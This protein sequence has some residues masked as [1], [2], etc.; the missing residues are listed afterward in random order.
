[1]PNRAAEGADDRI[2]FA[3]LCDRLAQRS[4]GQEPP[5]TEAALTVDDHDSTVRC[6]AQMLQS[7]VADDGIHA[8]LAE[9]PSRCDAV[10]A[11]R[12]QTAGAARE[13]QRLIPHLLP[14]R[15]CADETRLAGTAAVAARQDADA[16]AAC[17]QLA[18]EP[19]D[20]RRLA[21][22]ADAEIAN[23]H[24]RGSDPVLA[25][26]AMLISAAPQAREGAVESRER[27]EQRCAA[28][29]AIPQ[30]RKPREH[31]ASSRR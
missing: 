11:D 31:L 15:A 2:S 5:V 19:G 22:A 17:L 29:V 20:E 3:Q 6:Q 7:V 24:H 23:D 10:D 28:R 8:A 12:C 1:L 18:R 13:Q 9:E 27:S 16:E 30:L 26:H 21:R 25:Q 14:R 4:G